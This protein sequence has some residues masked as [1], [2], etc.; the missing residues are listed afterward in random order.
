MGPAMTAPAPTRENAPASRP[1][2]II[3]AADR[4]RELFTLT[5]RCDKVVPK[6]ETRVHCIGE[7]PNGSELV[8]KETVK[9]CKDSKL[10]HHQQSAGCDWFDQHSRKLGN[11]AIFAR[12]GAGTSCPITAVSESKI[13][14]S[15]T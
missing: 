11:W 5:V 7:I 9:L 8:A 12:F 14:D 4:M 3:L 6:S 15:V 10:R 13:P 1:A 2:Q